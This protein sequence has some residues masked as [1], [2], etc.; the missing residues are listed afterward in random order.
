MKEFG[1]QWRLTAEIILIAAVCMAGMWQNTKKTIESISDV[2]KKEEEKRIAITFDD[3]P[4]GIS[5]P[6]LLDGLKE[7]VALF[8][9]YPTLELDIMYSY[10]QSLSYAFVI[11]AI[12][13]LCTIIASLL[14][15]RVPLKTDEEYEQLNLEAEQAH[16]EEVARKRE[17]EIQKHNKHKDN[18]SI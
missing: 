10:G 2:K 13:V 12:I 14:V 8:P 3:G 16:E 6:V 7:I 1:K 17:R 18:G 5:T 4:D 11:C 15:K 9:Q